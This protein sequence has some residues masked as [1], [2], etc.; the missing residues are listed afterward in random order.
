[1]NKLHNI[2]NRAKFRL[3]L[4]SSLHSTA[5]LLIYLSCVV[6]ILAIVDRIS[7]APVIVWNVVWIIGAIIGVGIFAYLWN[8]KSL[9]QL[10][11]AAEIDQRMHLRDRISSA[12]ACEH[13]EN[14][15]YYSA[16]KED[17]ISVVESKKVQEK[18]SSS[19]PI[20]FPKELNAVIAIAFVTFFV[21]LSPQW[22]FWNGKQD[23]TEHSSVIASRENI[24]QSIDTVLEKLTEDESL[25]SS[26]EDELDELSATSAD[27]ISD[28][29]T[30][31]REALRKI[32]DLQK[33]LDEML[34]EDDPLTF[35][36][37]TNR[38][39]AIELP[40]NSK[41][42]P[43]VAA[44]KNGNFDQAKKEFEK[45]QEKME[46]EKLSEEEREEL[47]K[48]LEELAK[49]LEKLA[50]ANESLSSALSAAGMNGELANNSEAAMKAIKNSNL[51]EEQK[52]KL[53]ELLKAQQQASKMCK[54]M[55]S[56]CKKCSGG[57][58]DQAMANELAKLDAMQKFKTKAELAKKECQNAVKG[59][60]NSPGYG[61][62]GTGGIG[63][64]NGDKNRVKETAT[65]GVPERSPVHTI[66]G[67]IIARQLFEGGLLTTNE[68]TSTVK[69]TVLTQQRNAEQ[70]IADEEIPRKYHDLLKHYF[71]QLEELTESSNGS[72]TK[73]SD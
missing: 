65:K 48:S 30:L 62:S 42:L 40:K 24:E 41:T 55:S 28:P 5:K 69:E 10:E 50:S 8:R 52:K 32:T 11:A 57:N 49:Q 13:Q 16:L 27:T 53:L 1:M 73:S 44:M 58:G 38:M 7:V 46:S 66:E 37:M 22:G 34:Q 64:G 60:C 31:R 51:S 23:G 14:N 68:S 67:T 45:L 2:A 25:S 39:Q 35:D 56:S 18:L 21:L 20:S 29:E 15:P 12:I 70:A 36:E 43:L 4:N 3:Q 26:L 47:A 61:M 63:Q 6:L 17:A 19:F 9:S 54:K 33:R 71:G 72:T 59:M